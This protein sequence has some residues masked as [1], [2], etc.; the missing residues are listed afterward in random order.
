MF[1]FA[2]SFADKKINIPLPIDPGNALA[3][4]RMTGIRGVGV[5]AAFGLS[6]LRELP[7]RLALTLLQRLPVKR[8]IAASM[9]RRRH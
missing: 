8:T 4:V 3:G 6:L 7:S 1:I 9:N 2:A 5:L